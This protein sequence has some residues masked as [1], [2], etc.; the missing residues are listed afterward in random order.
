MLLSQKMELGTWSIQ[1]FAYLLFGSWKLN[2]CI[3]YHCSLFRFVN[4]MIHDIFDTAVK[5]V[6]LILEV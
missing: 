4:K 3:T 6:C 2:N 1:S 5:I